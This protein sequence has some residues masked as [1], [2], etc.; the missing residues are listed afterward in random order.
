MTNDTRVRH[1]TRRR[2]K[3]STDQA[4]DAKEAHEKSSDTYEV[5]Y[6]K[7]PKHT[8]F[9]PGQSGNPKGRPKGRKNFR[10]ELLEELHEM[11]AVREGG[12]R[13][14]VSKQRAMLKAL[15][16]KAVQGDA[17]AAS[18]IVNMVARFLQQEEEEPIDDQDLSA[19]DQAI[20]EAYEER[21]RRNTPVT[22]SPKTRRGAPR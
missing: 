10:T 19:E 17:R 7:P 6:G 20:L 4:A 1:R 11:I 5:G 21:I 15:N 16:A 9:K 22:R 18:L 12:K 8:R 13:R 3:P 2:S 14:R